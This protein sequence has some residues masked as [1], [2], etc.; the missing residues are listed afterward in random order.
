[1]IHYQ[2][3]CTQDH[4]FDGWFANST[5]F[6]DQAKRGL[7]ECPTCGSTHV[8]RALMAPALPVKSNRKPE[9]LPPQKAATPSAIP[10][11]V[12]AVLS[13]LRDVIE[14]NA[15]YVGEDFAEEARRIHEGEADARPIYGEATEEAAEALAEDGIEIARI[16]WLPRADS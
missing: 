10:A 11:E 14:K 1:M 6:E 16:P 12:R 15:D 2:L 4:S 5:S 7:L 8:E 9:I 3:R 13:R